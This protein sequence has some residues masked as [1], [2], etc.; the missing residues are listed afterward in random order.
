MGQKTTGFPVHF[1]GVDYPSQMAACRENG[2]SYMAFKQRLV[3]GNS[4]DDALTGLLLK[5]LRMEKII[6]PNCDKLP[7]GPYKHWS[8]PDRT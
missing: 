5:K 7:V 3:K 1:N 4:V 8:G 2:I 6:A